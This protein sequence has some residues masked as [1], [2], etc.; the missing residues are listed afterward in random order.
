MSKSPYRFT[1]QRVLVVTS[2]C[3][4]S[5]GLFHA[6]LFTFGSGRSSPSKEIL[7]FASC[8]F[9]NALVGGSLGMLPRGRI[10]IA[11]GATVGFLFMVVFYTLLPRVH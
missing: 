4:A 5:C 3:A 10:G 7:L 9:F 11:I 6:S 1:L 2:V 8:S